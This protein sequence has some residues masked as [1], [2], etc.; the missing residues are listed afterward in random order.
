MSIL[1]QNHVL[2][3]LQ[4]I[5]NPTIINQFGWIF[6]INPSHMS[7]CSYDLYLP[8]LGQKLE[9]IDGFH[10]QSCCFSYDKSWNFHEIMLTYDMVWVLHS[11][12][13]C[14]KV[15]LYV[16]ALTQCFASVYLVKTLS[17]FNF[18]IIFLLKYTPII[19]L[20]FD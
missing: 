12:V 14:V 7:R 16:G 3:L 17:M 2:P 20:K 8:K 13:L 11:T 4:S 19:R 9:I 18:I 5:K 10:D 15:L 6:I 1:S